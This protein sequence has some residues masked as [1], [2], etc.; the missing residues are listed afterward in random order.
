MNAVC[1]SASSGLYTVASISFSIT[2]WPSSARTWVIRPATS[3]VTS[4]FLYAFGCTTPGR[5]RRVVAVPCRASTSWIPARLI[6][7]DVRTISRDPGVS[8]PWLAAPDSGIGM[9]EWLCTLGRAVAA[10]GTAAAF[11][12]SPIPDPA[13]RSREHAAAAPTSARATRAEASEPLIES[14]A[15]AAKCHA[16]RPRPLQDRRVAGFDVEVPPL[17]GK[18]IVQ[19]RST[20]IVRLELYVHILPRQIAKAGGVHLDCLA[21]LPIADGGRVELCLRAQL[22]RRKRL[23]FGRPLREC[24]GDGA[25]IAVSHRQHECRADGDTMKLALTRNQP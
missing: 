2:R 6:I 4:T 15:R 23:L 16:R 18:Q 21:R 5:W 1:A 8:V 14:P 24:G 13:S 17:F 11:F 19:R 22:P 7:S 9:P 3:D 25:L 20:E 10:C 12:R